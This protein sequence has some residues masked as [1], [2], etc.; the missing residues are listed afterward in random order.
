MDDWLRNMGDWNISRR[1]YYGLP[2][3]FYPCSCGHLNVIGSKAELEERALEGFDQLEELRRPWVDRVPIA[4]ESCGERVTR[5]PEVGDVWLDAGIVPFA[6]LGWESAERVPEGYATGAARGLTKADLPDDAYWQKWF[7]ADWVSE[8]REQIRLWFYSQ[9]FMSVALV[10]RSPYRRVLAYE[11]MLDERGREMHASWGNTIAAE[12]AFAQMGADVMR[13][14]YCAQPPDRNLLFGYGPAHEIRRKLLTF[15]HSVKFLVDYANIEGYEPSWGALGVLDHATPLDRWLIARTQQLVAETT[16]A[17]EAT[18]T[19][20]VVRAFESF[21]DDLSNWYIRRSR[22]RFYSLDEAAFGS[23][24]YALVQSLRVMAPVLPFLSDHLWRN[25]VPDGP[26]SVHLAPWPDQ[27]TPDEALLAEMSDVR[28]VVELGRQARSTS[29]L[30]LRQPLRRL[31]VA[32]A[33]GGA[34][35]HT[36]EIADELRV[37]EVTFGEVE[38]SELRVKPNLPVLGPKL[39]A[40]LREVRERLA[41]GEFEALDGGR[42]RVDGHVLEPKEVLVE[43]VGREG[44]AV[45]S[46][47]GLT[48]ALDTALD[49]E[50]RREGRLLDWIHEVNGLRKSSGLAVTDRIRLWLPDAEIVET[51]A[52]RLQDETLAVSVEVG[53]LRLEKL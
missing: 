8:M 2:L 51:Y 3:P 40:A 10:G 41:R 13:W 53:E 14:Q 49:D 35:R 52:D 4:C 21:V 22:R 37:K 38:S 16:G 46:D 50:L 11:K 24:W 5:I 29:E 32:G 33:P 43:R 6:T 26:A 45:A 15:W 19:V 39:G 36:D 42:F 1:R 23:L 9:F 18:L 17:Y 48:V 20:D 30:K 12:D 34:V 31:V 44:W 47:D 27:E 25:L 7:P 28:R